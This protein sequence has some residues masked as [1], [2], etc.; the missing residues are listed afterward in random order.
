MKHWKNCWFLSFYHWCGQSLIAIK[1]SSPI[2]EIYNFIFSIDL[3]YTF[4]LTRSRSP[5]KKRSGHKILSGKKNLTFASFISKNHGLLIS[6]IAVIIFW[7]LRLKIIYWN[8]KNNKFTVWQIKWS[9]ILT[10]LLINL[11]SIYSFFSV[12]KNCNFCHNR[13]FFQI[14]WKAKQ[15][16]WKKYLL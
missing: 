13:Y 7:K 3:I 5:V 9:M 10:K 15:I 6:R 4:F 11:I 1:K 16:D 2:I 12:M 14:I 8:W